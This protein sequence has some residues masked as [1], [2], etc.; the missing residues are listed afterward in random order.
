[1]APLF[2]E[3]TSD[4]RWAI[5]LA[6]QRAELGRRNYGAFA[7]I[8]RE[9]IARLEYCAITANF[10]EF[11]DLLGRAIGA[12]LELAVRIADDPTGEPLVMAL[13][14]IGAPDDVCVRILAANDMHERGGFLR[15]HTLSRLSGRAS[16]LAAR[17]I[18]SAIL[19]ALGGVAAPASSKTTAAPRQP[20]GG[21]G[22]LRS[23]A[24]AR[25]IQPRKASTVGA[26]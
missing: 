22:T 25:S 10:L 24:A 2:L 13:V 18:M 4:Q 15:L 14:A 26:K 9:T 7:T 17:R 12:P 8:G 20:R 1:M 16:P 6:A 11:H 19:G 3:A 5:V 21:S 23:D